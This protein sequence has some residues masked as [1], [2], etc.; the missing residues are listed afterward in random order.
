[1]RAREYSTGIPNPGRVRPSAPLPVPHHDP[2]FVCNGP[3]LALDPGCPGTG[4]L[5]AFA[6][7]VAM[8]AIPA[9]AVRTDP[10]DRRPA[11]G[12][13]RSDRGFRTAVGRQGPALP[14]GQGDRH[15]GPRAPVG[16][17]GSHGPHGIRPPPGHALAAGRQRRHSGRPGLDQRG[18]RHARRLARPAAARRG[19]AARSA[20]ARPRGARPRGSGNPGTACALLVQHGP[21][22]HAGTDTLEPP[23]VL[24]APGTGRRCP[25]CRGRPRPDHV[26]PADPAVHAP[27]LRGAVGHVRPDDTAPV[28]TDHPFPGPSSGC[29]R[30]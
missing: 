19:L 11:A 16:V 4:R 20:G 9:P 12:R 21:G 10:A 23:A 8:G 7:P 15:M 30:G 13:A 26:P 2:A 1:M 17:G 5:S 3:P 29:A 14:Q 24:P 28:Y 6:R 27:G 25:Q 18:P 22:S